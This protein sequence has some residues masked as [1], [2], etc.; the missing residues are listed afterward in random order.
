M[1]NSA[2]KD[3][4]YKEFAN[5]IIYPHNAVSP[6][7]QQIM[8]RINLWFIK[9]LAGRLDILFYRKQTIGC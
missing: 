7:T 4:P 8:L 6:N 1:S 3:Q 9:K 5:L 2:W